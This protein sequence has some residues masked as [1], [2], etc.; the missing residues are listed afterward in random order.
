MEVQTEPVTSKKVGVSVT[1]DQILRAEDAP[2][3]P[4][5]PESMPEAGGRSGDAA[6]GQP[7]DKMIEKREEGNGE[8]PIIEADLMVSKL[9]RDCV[10][11]C[12]SLPEPTG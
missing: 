1:A 3:R 12:W 2:A 9:V 10:S 7:E 11:L 5:I 6:D 4:C 8:Q